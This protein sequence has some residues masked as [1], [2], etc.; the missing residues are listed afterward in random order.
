MAFSPKLQILTCPPT[1]DSCEYCDK[2]AANAVVE[3]LQQCA[4]CKLT[5]YCSKECQKADWKTHKKECRTLASENSGPSAESKRKE[6]Q[7][8][9]WYKQFQNPV[10][11]ISRKETYQRLIDCFRLRLDDE[12]N[13]WGRLRGPHD[14]NKNVDP[15]PDF[16]DFLLRAEDKDLGWRKQKGLLPDWWNEERRAEC[17]KMGGSKNYQA[18]LYFKTEKMKLIE[19]YGDNTMPLK[20]RLLA[21]K[22]EGLKLM[23]GPLKS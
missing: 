19:V 22:V 10:L 4:G 16:H 18:G 9:D 6:S 12:R 15:R 3:R 7:V 20:L 21:D 2:T 23:D 17:E 11:G 8:A 1:E 5:L 13:W 14:P